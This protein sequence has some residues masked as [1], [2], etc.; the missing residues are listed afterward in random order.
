MTGKN[1]EDWSLN[2]YRGEKRRVHIPENMS[3]EETIE[4][5]QRVVERTAPKYTSV[6]YTH[7]PLPTTPYV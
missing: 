5:I 3:E 6:S 1:G 7:L 2:N 4:T